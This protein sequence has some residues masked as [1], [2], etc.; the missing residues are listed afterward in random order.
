[1]AVRCTLLFLLSVGSLSGAALGLQTTTRVAPT[2]KEASPFSNIA[3]QLL[4]QNK[5]AEAL[6]EVDA[7]LK[8]APYDAFLHNLRGM[9]LSQLGRPQE[10]EDSFRNVIRLQPQEAIGYTNLGALLERMGR[11][12]EAVELFHQA[13]GRAPTSFVAL[14]GIG[15]NLATL[16]K[17]NEA[18][19]YLEKAWAAH[20]GDFR[21]G[22]QYARALREVKRPIEAANIL[23]QLT[24]PPYSIPAAQFYALSALVAEDRGDDV[25]AL[26]SY[27][28][29]YELSSASPELYIKLVQIT[30]VAGGPKAVE[31]LPPPPSQLSGVQNLALGELFAA[32]G[33]PHQA[34]THLEEVVRQEPENDEAAYNLALAYRA[35]G[36]TRQA[37]EFLRGKVERKPAAELLN[38]LASMEEEA[39]DYVEAV[40]HYQRA[41]EMEPHNED[42][43]FDLASEYLAH[44]NFEAA[45]EILLVG[46]QRFPESGRQYLGLGIAHFGLR[47]YADAARAFLTALE[48]E[49]SSPSAASAWYTLG[50]FLLPAEWEGYI[51]RLKHLSETHSTTAEV[52]FCLGTTLL[53]VGLALDKAEWLDESERALATAVRLK[54]KFADAHLELGSLFAA[55]KQEEKALKEFL[56]VVQLDPNSVAGLYRLGQTYR[57]LGRFELAGEV[58]ARYAKLAQMRNEKVTQNSQAVRM[59]IITDVR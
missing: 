46:T 23:L 29:A 45:L 38:L 32:H 56:Q 48:V 49:P 18:V 43:N 21:T 1:M 39:G 24:P 54:P 8:Q 19:P 16:G 28:R 58:L 12:K 11:N 7:G 31:S 47:Q 37:V 9:A 34:V 51:P 55:R 52:Q 5:F 4:A 10:A 20:P 36:E 41:V 2:T 33:A 50:P 27:R 30:L 14:L 42:Y 35:A 57:N 40:R 15:T 59:F 26:R 44:D 25:A 22:Y 6:T 13:L 53:R 3:I 17:Y